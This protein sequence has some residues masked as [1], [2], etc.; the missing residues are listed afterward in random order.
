M[1]TSDSSYACSVSRGVNSY[2]DPRLPAL[3]VALAYLG[4][5]EGP[6]WVAVR[7]TG[8]AYGTNFSREI[9]TGLLKYNIYRSPDAYNAFIASEKTVREIAEGT[10]ALNDLALEGAISSIVVS[11]ADEQPTMSHAANVGFVNQVIKGIPKDWGVGFLKKVRAVSK[12]E[13]RR[14]L[15]EIVLPVFNP[16]TANLIVTCGTIMEEKMMKGFN[17]AGFKPQSRTLSS[18]QD[19]Y[20]LGGEDLDDEDEVEDE[21]ED[22]EGEDTEEGTGSEDEDE[23]MEEGDESDHDEEKHS[24]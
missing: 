16:S 4:A 12:D 14:V 5:V 6:L 24:E 7:G 23:S 8:L 18:F 21:D 9:S 13:I 20:G 15:K 10:V 22:D 19:D 11:F 3:G 2:D 17:D 1:P